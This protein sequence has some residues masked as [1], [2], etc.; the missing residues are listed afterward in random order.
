MSNFT[1]EQLLTEISETLGI[2]HED[3][4]HHLD[5]NL[6]G[7]PFYK[8]AEEMLHLYLKLTK[9]LNLPIKVTDQENEENLFTTA[10]QIAQLL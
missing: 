3:L 7:A 2:S 6:F 9:V 1:K 4:H 10:N 8:T 5:T